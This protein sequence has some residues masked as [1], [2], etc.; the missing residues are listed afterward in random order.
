MKLYMLLHGHHKNP[1]GCPLSLT[2]QSLIERKR[3]I[4]S[5]KP[6]GEQTIRL[7]LIR[8][9]KPQALPVRAQKA[10]AAYAAACAARD[11]AGAT[12]ADA[13]DAAGAAAWATWDKARDAYD[14]AQDAFFASLTPEQWDR[15]HKKVCKHPDCKWTAKH[16]SIF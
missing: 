4:K 14:D 1:N 6:K 9:V 12:C 3:E 15:W 7:A 2:Y 5:H 13:R 11:A 10:W 8:N 16:P